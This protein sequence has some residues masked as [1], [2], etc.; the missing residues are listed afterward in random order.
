MILFTIMALI[1]VLVCI[2]IVAIGGAYLLIRWIIPVGLLI[3]LVYVI[4]KMIQ[5]LFR[6]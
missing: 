4:I 6:K 2:A 5:S 1:I 3:L